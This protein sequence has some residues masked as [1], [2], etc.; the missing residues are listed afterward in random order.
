MYRDTL[1]YCKLILHVLPGGGGGLIYINHLARIGDDPSLENLSV[2]T[3]GTAKGRG[4]SWQRLKSE[5]TRA[6]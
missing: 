2:V 3:E 1:E 6:I 4:R 5:R